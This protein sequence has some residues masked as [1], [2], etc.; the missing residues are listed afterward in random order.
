MSTDPG[1][2]EFERRLRA[3]ARQH[4]TQSPANDTSAAVPAPVKPPIRFSNI[5]GKW[6]N[7][8]KEKS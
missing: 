2:E 3:Q 1:M 7:A 8:H 4:L 5:S 6:Y